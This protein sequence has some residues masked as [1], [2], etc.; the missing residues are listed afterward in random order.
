MQ[1]FKLETGK[2]TSEERKSK[3]AR[4]KQLNGKSKKI[5]IDMNMIEHS[6]IAKDHEADDTHDR[7]NEKDISV[8]KHVCDISWSEGQ[9][10]IVFVC[11]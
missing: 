5:T 8:V 7:V 4:T 9:M 2:Y 3:S 11:L 6:S 10:V 1:D